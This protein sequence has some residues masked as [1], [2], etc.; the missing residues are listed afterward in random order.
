MNKQISAVWDKLTPSERQE[1]EKLL[2]AKVIPS[3]LRDSFPQQTLFIK[4]KSKLKALLG[5]RRMAKSYTAGLYLLQTALSRP[6]TASVYI[7]LT[8]DQTKRIVWDD[9]FKAI[10]KK[11]GIPHK[12]NETELTITLDN[13]SIIY[14][15]GVDDS[16]SEKDKL[17]GK[18]Y[19]LAIID[20]AASYTIDL[21]SLIYKVLKP[22]MSDLGGTICLI[23][24]P[25]DRKSGLFYELTRDIP[26][27]P[28]QVVD[29]QGWKVYTWSTPDNPYMREQWEETIRELKSADPHVEEQP[30]FQQHYLGRWVVDSSNQIYRYND[31]RNGWNGTL[32][33]YG[34]TRWNYVLG[35]DL[36]F[37]DATALVLLAYH[38]NDPYTY[39]IKADKWRG[40]TLTEAADKIR[41][42]MGEYPI[43]YFIVDGANKQG[44]EEIVRHHQL[45][46]VAADKADKVSFIRIMN[47]DFISGKIRVSRKD[48]G[49]L[50]EEY[51]KTIWNKRALERGIYKEDGAFHPDCADAALYAYRFTYAYAHTA[52]PTPPVDDKEKQKREW[53]EQ[54]RKEREER[55]YLYE[56]SEY[57]FHKN[58]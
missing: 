57:L 38:P 4:D 49:P 26:V 41:N 22:A 54:Y 44:V 32:P 35:I 16:E 42:W 33:D 34:W 39:I 8:R 31:D 25:D 58:W 10:L 5:T 46:L 13:G 7:G 6:G 19:A 30:W 40:L 47:S 11:Y 21:N 3:L 9:V 29:R 36:G 17:L 43:D 18:K 1:V 2:R 23:G 53:D 28:P 51:E 55:E 45:P 52:L 50:L 14:V 24:T 37:A 20:E 48:C 15:L 27:S 12:I 56:G